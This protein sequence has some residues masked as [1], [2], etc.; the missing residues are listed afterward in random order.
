VAGPAVR[1]VYDEHWRE[2]PRDPEPWR[3]AWRRA[4]LLG[5]LRDGERWLDLG[6]G[7]G[8]FTG[9]APKGIGVD[10]A[11]AALERARANVPGGDFRLVGDDGTLPLGHGEVSL[12]W[13]SE[14]IE[15][16][17]DALGLLQE[18]RRVLAPGG[19]LLLTTPGHPLL[20]RLAIAALRFDEHYD[21]Q[22]Q[23]V[24]FFTRA[25]LR[26]T[27]EAA[28]FTPV[29]RGGAHLVARAVR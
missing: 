4:L 2:L 27:L 11:P 17:P 23:H 6:C 26:R 19:R 5:E 9:L 14:T 12:V 3:F 24:R 10:I 16:V 1:R 15:H 25:S 7:A 29:V 18:A 8:R 28:G 21:P 20:R 13:C 22:G